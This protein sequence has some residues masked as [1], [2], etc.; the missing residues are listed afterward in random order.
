MTNKKPRKARLFFIDNLRIFLIILI[1]LHHLSIT[2][3]HAG[4]WYYLEG[5]PNEITVLV[6]TLFTLINQAYFLGFFYLIS[7]YFYTWLL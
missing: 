7:G 2:Y 1:V 3:G 4:K 6:N 5:Q